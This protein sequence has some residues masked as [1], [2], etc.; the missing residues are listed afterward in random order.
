M[1]SLNSTANK[2]L[3]PAESMRALE[4]AIVMADQRVKMRRVGVENARF[5]MLCSFVIPFASY[6]IY[7]IFGSHGVVHNHQTSAGAYLNYMQTWML[8]YRGVMHVY[9]PEIYYAYEHAS[10]QIYTKKIEEKKKDGTLPED[11]WYPTSWH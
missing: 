4:K 7:H 9:R 10:L 8:K 11:K 3:K 2:S 5:T 1:D 6:M